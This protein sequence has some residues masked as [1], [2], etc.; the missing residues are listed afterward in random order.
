MKRE[1][2]LAQI[3]EAEK[4]VRQAKDAAGNERERIL[5]E[6]RREAFELRESLRKTGEARQEEVLRQGEA[7]SVHEKEGVLAQGQKEAEALRAQANANVDRAVDRLIE[8]FK[9]A[10][11]A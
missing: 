1:E 4:S 10:L 5:R 9:G 11:N 7:A 2:T 8:K 6:A 3:K